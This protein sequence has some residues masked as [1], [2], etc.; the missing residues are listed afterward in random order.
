MI[1]PERL[2]ALFLVLASLLTS[3]DSQP[4][5]EDNTAADS[6]SPNAAEIVGITFAEVPE[7]VEDVR[8]SV[9]SVLVEGDQGSGVGSGVVWSE[10]GE[11]V[12][13]NHVIEGAQ[14][15]QIALASGE[16][17]DAEIV[18]T[19]PVTDL[20]VVQVDSRLPAAEFSRDLPEVGE[21]AVAMGSPLGFENTVTAGV[22]S[23]LHRSL[24]GNNQT[25]ALIDLIQT[26]AP[27]SPGNSGGAL[28]T[29][30]AQVT[31]INVAFI[32]PEA[33]AVSIGFAIPSPTVIEV[34]RQLIETG[35]VE[36]TFLG[37]IPAPVTPEVAQQLGLEVE[38]GV[39]ALEVV[40]GSP[41]DEAGLQPGDVI[42]Q[43]ADKSISTVVDLFE[44][45]RAT[46]PG[47]KVNVKFVR[48]NEEQQ[49]EVTLSDRP[50]A[51]RP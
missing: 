36:H 40:E 13:N 47:N 23:A 19:D 42:V 17:L 32:P 49:I 6:S 7:L 44:A 12:T 2:G 9:V 39:A 21:L 20:A 35:E 28:V 48:G 31:G 34:V 14:Q 3:C 18:A 26:D 45:L 33:R 4:A 37:I 16:Q 46:E 38:E 43:M 29:A 24:P 10:D 51:R 27:I 30:E 15:V 5:R 25:P 1:R 22:I 41:A 11:I 8:L 50:Q